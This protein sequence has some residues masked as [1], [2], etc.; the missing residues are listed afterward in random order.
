M[1]IRPYLAM[2]GAELQKNSG[3]PEK[4]AWLACHFSPYG[5]GLSNLPRALP[6]GALL[7]VD[8]MTPMHGHDP[9][10][11][12]DEL[13]LC[14]EKLACRGVLLDFQRPG[15]PEVP[16]LVQHLASCLPCPLAVSERYA[17]DTGLPVFLPPTDLTVP[18]PDQLESWNSQEIWLDLS[19][20]GE[21]L[22][23]TEDGCTASGL[24]PPDIPSEGFADTDLHCHYS[25]CVQEDRV[26]FTL[27]R[28]R[29][30][31]SDLLAE[32]EALGIHTAVGLFQELGD[33]L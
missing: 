29:E 4:A 30:D 23:L 28:T 25:I 22:H 27:W 9:V 18:L 14:T 7:I 3:I 17:E 13:T 24:I 10:L 19:C 12:C 33:L 31:L 21:I 32:A 26:S 1:A 11:I 8:D 20:A 16:S 5:T 6:A 15:N 2:T